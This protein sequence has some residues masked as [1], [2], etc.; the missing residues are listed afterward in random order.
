MERKNPFDIN[1]KE[2]VLQ[3]IEKS[4]NDAIKEEIDIELEKAI[5][6]IERRST[7]IIAGVFLEVQKHYKVETHSENVTFTVKLN[8]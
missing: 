2:D 5:Q 4:I 1:I 6:K 8:N 3:K 7:Q